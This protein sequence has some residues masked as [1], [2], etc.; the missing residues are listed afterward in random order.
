MTHQQVQQ[1]EANLEKKIQAKV[2]HQ[3]K[4]DQNMQ[5]DESERLAQLEQRF[6]QFEQQAH[7]TAVHQ[8]RQHDELRQQ[9]GGLQ[10]Q[11][12]ITQTNMNQV[13]DQRFDEQLHR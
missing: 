1:I 2:A 7:A 9:V 10:A 8:Q 5:V 3:A 11:I 13:L 6:S 12:E 4:D